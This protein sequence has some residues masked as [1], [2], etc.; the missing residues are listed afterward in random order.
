[1]VGG[2]NISRSVIVC[3]VFCAVLLG[4]CGANDNPFTV[5]IVNDT[6]QTVVDHG[7]FVTQR[8]T[9]KGGGAVTLK[10]GHSFGESEFADEGVDADRI[11]SP[12]GETLGCLP[13]KFSNNPPVTLVVK[14]SEMVPCGNSGGSSAVGGHDWPSSKY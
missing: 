1:V 9:S 2:V 14:V 4:A 3:V 10:P 12:G 6:A 5:T 8:G 11:T 7:Y 13:F